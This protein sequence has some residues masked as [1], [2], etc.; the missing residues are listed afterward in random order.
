MHY[1]DEGAGDVLLLVHGT[2]TWSFEWRHVIAALSPRWRCVAPDL[3]GFGLSERPR[4]FAYTPEAHATAIAEFVE[5]RPCPRRA[6]SS[7]PTR[8]T[9]PTRKR[10]SASSP[11]CGSS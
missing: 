3:I 9:G 4:G 7:S 5:R 6:W 2:P 8:A 10:P 11:R 1:V